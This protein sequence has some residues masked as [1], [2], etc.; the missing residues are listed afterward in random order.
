MSQLKNNFFR[1]LN[2]PVKIRQI[3]HVSFEMTS[4]FLFNRAVESLKICT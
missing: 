4:Q 3:S 1:F 2:A